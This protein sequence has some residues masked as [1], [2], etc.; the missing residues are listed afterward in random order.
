MQ[1]NFSVFDIVGPIIIGPS[2]SHTAG[3]C[4]LANA[5]RAIFNKPVTDVV[6]HVFGSFAA[7]L[8]GHGT[9]KALVGGI[10]GISPDDERLTHAMDI[11]HETG[12]EYRFVIEEEATSQPNLVR[13]EMRNAAEGAVMSVSGA[14]IGG[15]N[16]IVTRINNT[17]LKISLKYNTLI[18]DHLD[19]PGAVLSVAKILADHQ[20]NIAN[21]NMYRQ[22]KHGR[23]YMILET[24][25]IIERQVLMT[26]RSLEDMYV[27]YIP[28]LY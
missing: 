1:N 6:I 8:R 20:I 5:A 19:K 23:A 10:M 17:A 3:A 22:G 18:V 14:S 16:I 24:D 26:L 9:D 13:F 4:R 21:M 2:S 25:Q 27:I 7:T 15:G 11:A 28:Q 12:L